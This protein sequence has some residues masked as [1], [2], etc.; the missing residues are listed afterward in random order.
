MYTHIC[1]HALMYF[2]CV[3]GSDFE[4]YVIQKFQHLEMKISNVAKRLKQILDKISNTIQPD[5][6]QEKINIFQDL[7]LKNENELQAIEIKLGNDAFYGGVVVRFGQS[8]GP[9]LTIIKRIGYVVMTSSAASAS[10]EGRLSGVCRKP[11]SEDGSFWLCLPSAPLGRWFVPV[12]SVVSL[13]AF[14]KQLARLTGQDYKHSCLS[15]MRQIISNEVAVLFSWHGA[16]KR[17]IF[18]N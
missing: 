8:E 1:I 9:L 6:E 5:K 10:E 2:E 13:S 14:K 17:A 4:R 12:A 7:P 16:K 15:L 18:L 11:H 3:V